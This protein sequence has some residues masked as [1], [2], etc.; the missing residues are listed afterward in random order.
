MLQRV[1]PV[2]LSGEFSLTASCTARVSES[3]RL[4]A[5]PTVPRKSSFLIK[6]LPASSFQ[7]LF[8]SP[9]PLENRSFT[10]SSLLTRRGFISLSNSRISRL[11]HNRD[12]RLCTKY[13]DPRVWILNNSSINISSDMVGH[14]LVIWAKSNC[15]TCRIKKHWDF[16]LKM[17]L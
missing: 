5:D 9:N 13:L 17:K 8:S 2:G 15:V 4:P 1:F 14:T 6:D 11:W 7:S 12:R 16:S 10:L 3:R